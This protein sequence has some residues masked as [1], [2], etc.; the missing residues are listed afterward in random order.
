MPNFTRHV[1]IITSSCISVRHVA[2]PD[3]SP[4]PQFGS[5]ISN[6]LSPVYSIE[7]GMY[8]SSTPHPPFPLVYNFVPLFSVQSGTFFFF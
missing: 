6:K 2:P 3:F 7:Y 5:I 8:A 4:K 1:V